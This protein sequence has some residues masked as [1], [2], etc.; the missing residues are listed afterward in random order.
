M[1]GAQEVDLAVLYWV[2]FQS[3]CDDVEYMYVLKRC[4]RYLM[5][6]RPIYAIAPV[7]S[8]QN[9]EKN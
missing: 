5:Y 1:G 8:T 6:S 3:H 4:G 7:A 9:L 2:V